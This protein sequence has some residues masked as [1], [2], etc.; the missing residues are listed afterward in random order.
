VMPDYL[1]LSGDGYARWAA[2]IKEPVEKLLK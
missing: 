1:H 2:A